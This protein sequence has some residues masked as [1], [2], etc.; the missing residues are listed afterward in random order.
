MQEEKLEIL[1]KVHKT[2]SAEVRHEHLNAWRESGLSMNE[3]C[4]RHKL[5]V[6]TLSKWALESGIST[7]VKLTPLK[8]PSRS[9]SAPYAIPL[10]IRLPSGVQIRIAQKGD[11]GL[12]KS[13]L[14]VIQS[15]T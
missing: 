8:M 2:Y 4:R 7:Q 5:A 6:S 12:L 9:P 13:V 15:C 1:K 10:E 11:I 3:Y 14:E